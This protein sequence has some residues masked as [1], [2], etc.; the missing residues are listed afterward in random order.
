M[1]DAYSKQSDTLGLNKIALTPRNIRNEIFKFY[2]E[3]LHP[4]S[5]APSFRHCLQWALQTQKFYLNWQFDFTHQLNFAA[6]E[7]N[8]RLAVDPH[9]GDNLDIVISAAFAPEKRGQPP[10]PWAFGNYDDVSFQTVCLTAMD[11]RENQHN[12]EMEGMIGGDADVRT[13]DP[14][15]RGRGTEN[16]VSTDSLIGMVVMFNDLAAAR[17]DDSDD[18]DSGRPAGMAPAYRDPEAQ[19]QAEEQEDAE[20]ANE[21]PRRPRNRYVDG[22]AEG[23]AGRP[24]GSDDDDE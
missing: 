5:P 17:D 3:H 21:P 10:G 13:P 11:E 16:A 2:R 12:T 14:P 19:R 20:F 22:E 23:P 15:R 7:A 8:W 1:R 24:A 9:A 6:V 4:I 18:D